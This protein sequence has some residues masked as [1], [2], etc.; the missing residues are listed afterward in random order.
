MRVIPVY[1]ERRK[2]G[3]NNFFFFCCL[4]THADALRAIAHLHLSSI[5]GDSCQY[6]HS[7][8]FLMPITAAALHSAL[9]I[10]CLFR[11]VSPLR[12]HTGSSTVEFRILLQLVEKMQIMTHSEFQGCIHTEGLCCTNSPAYRHLSEHGFYIV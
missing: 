12:P 1:H 9:L 3:G 8:L 7:P 5:K 4:R 11:Y 6:I 10:S 2:R